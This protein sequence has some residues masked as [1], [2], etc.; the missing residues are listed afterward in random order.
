MDFALI[1]ESLPQLIHGAMLALPM[2]LCCLVIAGVLAVPLSIIRHGPSKPAAL[3]L[4][5]WSTA[6]RGTPLLVQLFLIYY[7]LPQLEFVRQSAL[8]VWLREPMWCAIIAIALNA[9]AYQMELFAGAIASVPKGEKEAAKALGLHSFQS[10][11]FIILPRAFRSVLPSYGNELILTLKATSL[12]STVTIMELTGAARL[13]V[14]RTYAPYEVFL[15]A[16]LL[17]L[18]ISLCLTSFMTVLFRPAAWER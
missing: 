11:R 7:G 15:A 14:S 4:G 10:L 6:T 18:I 12:G 3:A 1:L 13:I 17:Y 8:W 9:A 5:A 2:T 16:A